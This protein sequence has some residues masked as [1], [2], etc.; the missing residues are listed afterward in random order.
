MLDRE[1]LREF[2][3]DWRARPA[4]DT[5]SVSPQRGYLRGV[6]RSTG[7]G[8]DQR[9]APPHVDDRH[10]TQ[11]VGPRRA[12]HRPRRRRP[13]VRPPAL[14]RDP[15]TWPDVQPLPVPAFQMDEAVM[16][17]AL[18]TL[19][20]A[21][22]GGM[23][24]HAQQAG[25]TVPPELTDPASPPSAAQIIAFLRSITAQFFPRLPHPNRGQAHQAA[26]PDGSASARLAVLG[27]TPAWDNQRAA[28]PAAQRTV[29]IIGQRG[30][31]DP[32]C[33]WGGDPALHAASRSLLHS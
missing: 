16:S 21:M 11:G 15:A 19:G 8:A 17:K 33:H 18:S 13:H 32:L 1:H 5:C 25:I 9:R 14:P 2:G 30:S 26:L 3:R 12:V 27:L 20:H 22:G 24:E 28:W 6:P 10:A 7:C 23:L 4:R 31:E 29:P